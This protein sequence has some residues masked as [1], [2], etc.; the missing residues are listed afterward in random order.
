[1]FPSWTSLINSMKRLSRS[2]RGFPRR[3]FLKWFWSSSI[4][5]LS[6]STTNIL[7]NLITELILT[8]TTRR[9]WKVKSLALGHPPLP[10]LRQRR[11]IIPPPLL[12]RPPPNLLQPPPHL[13]PPPINLRSLRLSVTGYLFLQPTPP[14]L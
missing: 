9:R 10:N 14:L 3:R 1:M 4:E 5:W 6:G 7:F 2:L 8:S 12:L 11:R 13:A